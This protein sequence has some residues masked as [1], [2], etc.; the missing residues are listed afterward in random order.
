MYVSMGNRLTVSIARNALH[1]R[2]LGMSFLRLIDVQ[3]L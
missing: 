1:A 2:I 3:I